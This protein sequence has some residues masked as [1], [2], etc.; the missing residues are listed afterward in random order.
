MRA[1]VEDC[2]KE[3]GDMELSCYIEN[4]ET[5]LDSTWQWD[6]LKSAW[7]KKFSP[8]VAEISFVEDEAGE[9]VMALTVQDGN[10]KCN[11]P[12]LQGF[13][14]CKDA[15]FQFDFTCH[16]GWVFLTQAFVFLNFFLR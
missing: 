2:N 8:D 13:N 9:E 1:W 14:L 12:Q 7:N 16:Y 3:N 6:S 5:D 11:G 15:G 10:K 4:P